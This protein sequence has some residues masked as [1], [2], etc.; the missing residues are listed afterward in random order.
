MQSRLRE[1][2]L[3][4]NGLARISSCNELTGQVELGGEKVAIL[5]IVRN[6]ISPTLA[7]PP[8]RALVKT[9]HAGV[10]QAFRAERRG[11]GG[12]IANALNKGKK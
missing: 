10:T 7:P 5:K 9:P 6:Y 12:F 2:D 4:F 3:G 8:R 1:R 11:N